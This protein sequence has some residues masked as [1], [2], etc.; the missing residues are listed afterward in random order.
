GLST[1]LIWFL[2]G[3]AFLIAGLFLPGFVLIFF[4]AGCW[5]TG[6]TVWLTDIE[7]FFQILIFIISSLALLITLRKY[8][9]KIFKG[10]TREDLDDRYADSK[11]GK[12]AL[13]TKAITPNIPGEIKVKGSFWRAISDVNIEEGKS[14]LIA[15]Q[16]SDDGLTFKVKPL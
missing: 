1:S 14:V 16:E 10:T 15:S 8:S 5:I 2:V 7:A 9:I 13:V 12:T 6:L 4:T 3:V 11:I